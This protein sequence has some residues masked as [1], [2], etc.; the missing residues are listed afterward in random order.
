MERSVKNLPAP[1]LLVTV[2]QMFSVSAVAFSDVC[3]LKAV[4]QTSSREGAL[5]QGPRAVL[6]NITHNLV[7]RAIL[8]IGRTGKTSFEKLEQILGSLLDDARE[9]LNGNP[10]TATYSHLPL[11]MSPLAWA[12]K[13][14]MIL[15]LAYESANSA[16]PHGTTSNSLDH[17]DFRFENLLWDGR[18]VEVPIEVSELR[19]KG[20]IDVLN[21]RGKIAEISDIK[22]GRVEDE[23]GDLVESIVRQ[24]QLYGLMASWLEPTTQVI[25][26][27][28]AGVRRSIPFGTIVRDETLKWLRSIMD[29][30]PPS[31]TVSCESL[32]Q[33]GSG[34]R[35]CNMRHRCV[36]Y[37]REA[38]P[39]WNSNLD[40]VLPLD[41]WGTI[42]RI[43]S[44]GDNLVDLTLW[45][46]IGRHVKVFHLRDTQLAGL[47]A[48]DRIW[49]FELS[50]SVTDL[51][52]LSCRHPLNFHEMGDSAY[53]RAWSIQVFSDKVA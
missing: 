47:N 29:P 19:L 40:W 4:L 43:D 14:R 28:H 22:S 7:D 26:S 39:H 45:D 17:C 12:R 16:K 34:C 24:I 35:W 48:G 10:L 20:R 44:I 3:L 50:A 31:S 1:I 53:D 42:D 8:G 32:A 11:T 25:L 36:R 49:L 23:N 15:D 6:G 2:P 5:L 21:R 27:I 38:P 30:I 52:G 18:W 33:V 46:A 13:R 41:I 37:L 9:R 51:R